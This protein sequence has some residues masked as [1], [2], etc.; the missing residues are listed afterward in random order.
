MC[1]FLPFASCLGD[2]AGVKAGASGALR[3]ACAK[4]K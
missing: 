4:A 1:H 3:Y 2:K